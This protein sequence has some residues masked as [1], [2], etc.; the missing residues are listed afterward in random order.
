MVDNVDI[1]TWPKAVMA[2]WQSTFGIGVT[3]M[4]TYSARR[5]GSPSHAV[6]ITEGKVGVRLQA[7]LDHTTHIML[8]CRL[9]PE[10]SARLNLLMTSSIFDWSQSRTRMVFRA[11]QDTKWHTDKTR[12]ITTI[13]LRI[14]SI[15]S[16]WRGI[17]VDKVPRYLNETL[18]F[19]ITRQVSQTQAF[20]VSY[21][22]NHSNVPHPRCQCPEVSQRRWAAAHV[23]LWV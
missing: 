19:S 16:I 9:L 21:Y 7:L 15:M 22:P 17:E 11:R 6:V 13:M 4:D 18:V 12:E 3:R 5:K 14:T 1:A 23:S 10:V 2:R 20:R 8:L